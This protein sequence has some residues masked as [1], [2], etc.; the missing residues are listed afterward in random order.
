M[1][2]IVTIGAVEDLYGGR[3]FKGL[4]TILPYFL[5]FVS[6]VFMLTMYTLPY[7]A[8]KKRFLKNN[9]DVEAYFSAD[10]IFYTYSEDNSVLASNKVLFFPQVFSAI[11]F[12]RIAS[13]K[14]VKTLWEH[15]VYFNLVNDK[16]FY[17][18]NKNYDSIQ[19]AI[20]ANSQSQQ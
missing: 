16:S 1:F 14:H 9:E 3:F 6:F 11:P 8:T 20:N 10:E 12:D 7:N 2:F 15:D 19:A 4:V 5:P 17:I 13:T 18:V